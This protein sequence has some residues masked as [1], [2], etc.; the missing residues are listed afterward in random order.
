M[1]YSCASCCFPG[2]KDFLMAICIVSKGMKLFATNIYT[3][4]AVISQDYPRTKLQGLS[5][6]HSA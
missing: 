6:T 2:M 1:R 5:H 4:S 3:Y